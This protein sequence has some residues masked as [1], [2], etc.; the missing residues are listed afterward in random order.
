VCGAAAPQAY[1]AG[2]GCSA[3]YSFSIWWGGEASHELGVQSADVSALP[4]ALPHSSK[5]PASCQSPWITEV[6]RSV[7]VFHG[8]IGSLQSPIVLCGWN[9]GIHGV[10][11]EPQMPC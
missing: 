8:H 9:T 2:L 1:G 5:S 3:C 4:S 7:A 10:H 11:G 6:R